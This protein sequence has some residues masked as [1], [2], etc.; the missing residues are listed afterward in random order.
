MVW[1]LMHVWKKQSSPVLSI[2]CQLPSETCQLRLG[3]VMI[4]SVMNN[5]S[6]MVG[7][8]F[9]LPTF[10]VPQLIRPL[11]CSDVIDAGKQADSE[12][13]FEQ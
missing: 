6:F 4:D 10:S 1:P 12:R 13:S 11:E 5:N 7:C 2:S 9:S 8:N 3:D